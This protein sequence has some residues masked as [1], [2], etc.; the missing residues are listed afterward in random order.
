MFDAAPM[1]A[2][3]ETPTGAYPRADPRTRVILKDADTQIHAPTRCSPPH[4]QPVIRSPA[5]VPPSSVAPRI[6]RKNKRPFTST[7]P[8]ARSPELMVKVSAWLPSDCHLG[9]SNLVIQIGW[10][11]RFAAVAR[12]WSS[13]IFSG[14]CLLNFQS[15]LVLAEGEIRK[16]RVG[17]IRGTPE[18]E[19]CPRVRI[20]PIHAYSLFNA[21]FYCES[22]YFGRG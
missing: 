6:K 9:H 14:F 10:G 2:L 3:T 12:S 1:S 5:K 18:K 8:Q 11:I 13:Q 7:D 20:P 22:I 4:R 19:H 16:E 21:F 17:G 15:Y